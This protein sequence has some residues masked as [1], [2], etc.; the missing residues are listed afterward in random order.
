M[1]FKTEEEAAFWREAYLA[2][3]VSPQKFRANAGGDDLSPSSNADSAVAN[4][5]QRRADLDELGAP[6]R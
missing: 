5:R 6:Y 1:N 3:V 2:F 4:W